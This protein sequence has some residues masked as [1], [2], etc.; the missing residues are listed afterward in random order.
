VE[1]FGLLGKGTYD[2]ETHANTEEDKELDNTKQ[3]AKEY[4][5]LFFINTLS[6]GY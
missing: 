5:N 1:G 2:I 6:L 4:N 3:P